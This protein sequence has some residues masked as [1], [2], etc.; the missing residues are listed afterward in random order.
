[1]GPNALPTVPNVDPVPGDD[2]LIE[3]E[4]A[5]Q[6][7]EL[8]SAGDRSFTPYA[9]LV[10]PFRGI[11]A[12]EADAIPFEAWRV[13]PETQLRLGSPTSSGRTR[14][15]VRFGARFLLLSEG[16]VL[17]AIGL[18]F[19]TKT[20]TGKGFAERRFTNSPAYVLDLIF[21]KDLVGPGGPGPRIRL[22]A[23]AGFTAWEQ[24]ADDQDDAPDL[25]ATLQLIGSWASL[26]VEWRGY[27]GW[28]TRDKP[29][30]LGL[31]GMLTPGVIDIGLTVNRGLS[32]DAPPWEARFGLI[33][34]IPTFWN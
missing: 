17:P 31:R 12:L 1:M 24:G 19:L 4:G 21:G 29:Q 2:I 11:A 6:L 30:V 32:A 26:Q 27:F 13:S 5:A 34:H 28:E 20:T 15:D 25:G 8:G 18:R 23:K 7:S 3:L 10:I 22:L 9:R 16:D 14:G 33:I